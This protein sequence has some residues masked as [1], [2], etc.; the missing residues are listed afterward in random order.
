MYA[1]K[2]VLPAYAARLAEGITRKGKTYDF[3]KEA[4]RKAIWKAIEDP[5][6]SIPLTREHFRADLIAITEELPA[7]LDEDIKELKKLGAEKNKYRIKEIERY[8][9]QPRTPAEGY[10]AY[11]AGKRDAIEILRAYADPENKK[12]LVKHFADP[13]TIVSNPNIF[14]NPGGVY[15]VR[16][17]KVYRRGPLRTVE[18][19]VLHAI[20]IMG[21]RPLPKNLSRPSATAVAPNPDNT[22]HLT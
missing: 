2:H 21:N 20:E 1:Y 10:L 9:D 18:E 15:D 14:Y 4:D 3:T 12:K 7:K 5:D 16:G 6:V 17:E 13:R 8:R 22:R 19:T 11:V